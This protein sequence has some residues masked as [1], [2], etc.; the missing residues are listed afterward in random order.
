MLG[1]SGNGMGN[2]QTDGSNSNLSANVD[3]VLVDYASQ[4]PTDAVVLSCASVFSIL[5][6]M[7]EQ[8]VNGGLVGTIVT[9]IINGLEEVLRTTIG[10]I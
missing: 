5:D 1:L 8:E 6:L 2:A 4:P 3:F 7:F 9:N 10:G